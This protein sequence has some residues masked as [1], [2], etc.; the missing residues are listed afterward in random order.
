ML[1]N[2]FE[3]GKPTHNAKSIMVTGVSYRATPDLITKCRGN[4]HFI[5]NF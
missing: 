5:V 3:E 4:E 2:A 1:Q